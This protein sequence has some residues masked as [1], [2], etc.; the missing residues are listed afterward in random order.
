MPTSSIKI[1]APLFPIALCFMAGIVVADHIPHLAIILIAL[2]PTLLTVFLLRRFPRWQTVAICGVVSLLG[3]AWSNVSK[4]SLDTPWPEGAIS[5]DLVVVSE[6]VVSDRFIV[7]DALTAHGHHKLRCR[8]S[9]DRYS[10]EIALG[11]G[12]HAVSEVTAIHE[13][14]A[15]HFDYQRYMQCHRYSGET[16]I[17]GGRWRWTALSLSGLSL[18][19]RARLQALLLRHQLL[20]H[21]RQWHFTAGEYGVVAAMTLG[22]KSQLNPQLKDIYS[23]VGASHVLALSG[24]HL[25]II[26]AVISMLVGWW[27]FRTLS[28]VLIVLSIWAFAFLVGLSPSVVRSAFMISVYALLS[29]GCRERMSV[30]TLAFTALL[31]LLVNPFSLYDVGFQLSFL[32][33]LSIITLYPLFTAL[34]P[35]HILQRHRWLNALWT[36]TTVSFSAQLGTAPL[37]A[38]YFG[39]WPTYFLLSNFLVIPLAT[40]ILYLVLACLLTFWWSALQHLL[41]TALASVVSFMN[42]VLTLIASL[43]KSSVDNIRLSTLQVTFI[44][45]IICCSWVLLYLFLHRKDSQQLTEV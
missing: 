27:R 10:R 23:R 34:I 25:M 32:A 1:H 41:V 22:D 16:F 33:V 39:K 8:V 29:L 15:G 36:L 35:L 17:S 19:E 12:L 3:A 37:V 42:S 44:Y 18:P 30:N 14:H 20:D 40:V 4:T 11:H 28:Q 31:M 38:Y 5:Q 21:Y 2:L 13:W 7:F 9:K 6:P 43:P 45:L 26:Y 24:L